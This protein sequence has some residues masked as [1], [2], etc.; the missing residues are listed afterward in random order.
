MMTSNVIRP[1]R[2]YKLVES[3]L[4]FSAPNTLLLFDVPE[5]GEVLVSRSGPIWLSVWRR[6]E[7]PPTNDF[8]VAEYGPPGAGNDPIKSFL[9]ASEAGLV[10]W[11]RERFRETNTVNPPTTAFTQ[12]SDTI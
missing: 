3:A 2:L 7:G 6:T 5:K 9:F 8:N 4:A 11:L 1:S 10:A 12:D